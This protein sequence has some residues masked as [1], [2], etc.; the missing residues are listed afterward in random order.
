[1]SIQNQRDK[2]NLVIRTHEILVY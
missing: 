1:M 2:E